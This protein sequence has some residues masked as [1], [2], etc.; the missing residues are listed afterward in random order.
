M[1]PMRLPRVVIAD[2]MSIFR[3]GVCT[4]LTKEGGF[5]VVAAADL[6]QL[7][8]VVED[9]CPD[10]ALIDADLPPAGGLLAV[11]KLAT[12]FST[13]CIVWSFAPTPDMVLAAIR[14]GA[15]GY[16][17]K[18]ISSHGLVSALR[19]LSY[20]E[21][22]LSRSLASALVQGVRGLGASS[23]VLEQAARLSAREREVL[24][25]VAAGH[26]N[27]QVASALYISEFTVKRHVQNILE[28]LE[29][30]SRFAAGSFYSSAVQMG[31]M[32]PSA[33]TTA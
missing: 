31:A 9:E 16:L 6:D 14:A 2:P 25:L 33:R 11:E 13:A 23:P 4:L 15:H 5:D 26:R 24:E 29:L 32:T 27:K 20:G 18:S 28:K 10:L 22:P 30:P 8:A 3:S 17:T 19:G 7:V 12:R 21:A 1:R